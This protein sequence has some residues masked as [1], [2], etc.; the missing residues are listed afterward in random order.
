MTHYGMHVVRWKD[1]C[2]PAKMVVDISEGGKDRGRMLNQRDGDS[3]TFLEA[4]KLAREYATKDTE[5]VL[6]QKPRLE[7]IEVWDTGPG[8]WR[9]A[10]NMLEVFNRKQAALGANTS[11]IPEKKAA[12]PPPRKKATKKVLETVPEVPRPERK[13]PTQE[14]FDALI[15]ARRIKAMDAMPSILLSKWGTTYNVPDQGDRTTE[16]PETGSKAA[17]NL[18]WACLLY[19]SPSP[20]D[21]RGSRMPS[22][23]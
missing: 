17:Y 16:N 7:D 12:V 4:L 11:S 13:G 18:K 1:N 15:K 8:H 3:S 22:S 23:A 14:D 9:K 5:V 20:R 21:Q 19:T 6:L 2:L 10:T